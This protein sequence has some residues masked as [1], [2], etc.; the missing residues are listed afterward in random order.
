MLIFGD[1]QRTYL[2][3]ANFPA[4]D[5]EE[6]SK[7]LRACLMSAEIDEKKA[8]DPFAGLRF[9]VTPTAGWKFA[10]SMLD[11]LIFTPSGTLPKKPDP[12]EGAFIVVNSINPSQ[13][14]DRK[15]F[16]E[17]RFF[18]LNVGKELAIESNEPVEV[19]GMPGYE[20]VGAAK[21]DPTGTPICVY[22]AMLFEPNGEHYAL[23][24]GTVSARKREQALPEFKAMARSYKQKPPQDPKPQAE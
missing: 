18:K 16:A 24:T 17:K 22:A 19:D 3:T 1:Q 5:T 10:Q 14:G 21:D 11:A 7:Q 20:I 8:V 23:M 4:T 15:R 9:T 2:I 6:L 13:P 12:D